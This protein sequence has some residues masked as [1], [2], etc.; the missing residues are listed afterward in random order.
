MR[1]TIVIVLAVFC[2]V[3]TNA[4]SFAESGSAPDPASALPSPLWSY[5]VDQDLNFNLAVRQEGGRL[6]LKNG[7]NPEASV[8]ATLNDK[9]GA[10]LSSFGVPYQSYSDW[11]YMTE[12]GSKGEIYT[13]YTEKE[14]YRLRDVSN[15]GVTLWD[16]AFPEKVNRQA[17]ITGIFMQPSGNLLVYIRLNTYKYDVYQFNSAGQQLKM[18]PLN[19]FVDRYQNGYLV[20]YASR[21]SAG[22]RL[23]FYDADLN[24]KFTRDIT[25]RKDDFGGIDA[26]G[27]LYFTGYDATKRTSTVVARNAKGTLLWSRT[28]PGEVGRY[29]ESPQMKGFTVFVGN[30]LY[31]FTA[32]GLAGKITFPGRTDFQVARDQSVFAKDGS[33]LYLLNDRL[34]VVRTA[35][36]A[37]DSRS[38]DFT[39]AGGGILYEFDWQTSLLSKIDWKA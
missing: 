30:T 17:G 11:N 19:E 28:L 33:R 1:K 29:D 39:Y 23:S 10:L 3:L 27:T 31:R 16:K 20:T 15:Q 6:Y 25:F 2:L 8:M 9:N 22:A 7:G 12:I 34:G 21:G 37:P 36:I 35:D 4:R 18:K 13:L 26:S 32:N 14:A 5:A 38:R 24:R